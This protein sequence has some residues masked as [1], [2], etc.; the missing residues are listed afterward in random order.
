MGQYNPK[1]TRPTYS[2]MTYSN[3]FDLRSDRVNT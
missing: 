3:L 2:E 1:V